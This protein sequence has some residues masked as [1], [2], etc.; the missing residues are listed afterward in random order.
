LRT[1]YGKTISL[2]SYFTVKSK[3]SKLISIALISKDYSLLG[4]MIDG[5]FRKHW[6]YKI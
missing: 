1:K 5:F 3:R 4:G 6:G 2:T